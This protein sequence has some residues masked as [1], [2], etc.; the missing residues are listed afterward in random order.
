M[1][2]TVNLPLQSTPTPY[3]GGLFY[4]A[5]PPYFHGVLIKINYYIHYLITSTQY[6]LLLFTVVTTTTTSKSNS[7]L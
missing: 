1:S 5:P 2:T 4:I 7:L 3:I 6:T